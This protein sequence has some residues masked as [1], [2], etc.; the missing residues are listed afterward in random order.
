M[1]PTIVDRQTLN[2]LLHD[3]CRQTPVAYAFF[4]LDSNNNWQGISWEEFGA[5]TDRVARFLHQ[6]GISHGMRIGILA[7]TSLEW[8]VA[9]MGSL[10]I[11]TVV[12]GIDPNYPDDQMVSILEALQLSVL[13]V[14]NRAV[15]ERIRHDVKA[16][17]RMIVLFEDEAINSNERCW[18]TI[19]ENTG[20]ELPEETR[21]SPV[22]L[23]I[24]VFSSG[25][26]GTPKAI[27]YRH[28]QVVL[29]VNTILER[30]PSLQQG[31]TMLC[32]LPLANLF[33]RVVNFCAMRLGATSY[34]LSDP[35]TLPEQIRRI[36]PEILVVVPKILMRF[37]NGIISRIRQRS[38]FVERLV[39]RV[40]AVSRYGQ[41]HPESFISKLQF[42]LMDWLLLK[43]LRAVFGSRIQYF[44]CGSAAVP[45]W[46]IEWYQAIGL[47]VY[48]AYGVSENIVPIAMNFPGQYKIGSVG[49]PLL[50]GS[51]RITTEGEVAV[52]GFGVFSGYLPGLGAGTERWSECGEWLTSD[53]GQLD[54]GGFLKLLGRKSDV[55][56]TSNGKWVLPA[57]V[58]AKFLKIAYVECCIVFQPQLGTLLA[59]LVLEKN[60]FN[61]RAGSGIDTDRLGE[62]ILFDLARIYPE[63]S[64][65][66]RP[67]G[68]I[69][70]FEP[71]SLF[72]GELTVNMKL[73]RAE[74][75]RRIAP[76]I[77]QILV[78]IDE[79][80]HRTSGRV[81]R[82]PVILMI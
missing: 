61:R 79:D 71:L 2:G 60:N 9:Q 14:Q 44:I 11:A 49:H 66:Q 65:Y 26:S 74:I 24:I 56:K 75:L 58:E 41:N 53:F 67:S 42:K 50:P 59:F 48:E 23:A 57:D 40:L 6:S 52:S 47:P 78:K 38:W 43:R 72:K 19:L 35:R 10:A 76:A 13:F 51:V 22:D 80:Q 55:F 82:K 69:V 17:I 1:I 30:F 36:N 7:C 18:R 33:Q 68:V 46:L 31:M 45:L 25:T 63:L 27:A 29:T 81:D 54:D 34:L 21:P 28:D 12:A 5:L 3:R 62:I 64:F 70:T 37:H 8:E 20:N 15:L 32:W 4:R 39:K 73:R 77:S 16:K